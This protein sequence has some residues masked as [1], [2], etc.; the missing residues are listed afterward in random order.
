MNNWIKA[1]SLKSKYWSVYSYEYDFLNAQAHF[2]SLNNNN[3]ILM[4]D[5]EKSKIEYQIF[6]FL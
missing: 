5:V 2:R 1:F 3:K 4:Y 6:H